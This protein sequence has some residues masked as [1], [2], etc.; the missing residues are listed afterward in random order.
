MDEYPY[1]LKH[2]YTMTVLDDIE[3]KGH[4]L[5]IYMDGAVLCEISLVEIMW[6]RIVIEKLKRFIWSFYPTNLKRKKIGEQLHTVQKIVC[7][8]DALNRVVDREARRIRCNELRE[9]KLAE[10]EGCYD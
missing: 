2:N 8:Q 3:Y 7:E 4:R 5:R 10:E 1:E 6:H 9:K